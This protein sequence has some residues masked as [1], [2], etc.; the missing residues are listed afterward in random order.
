MHL[1]S[2]NLPA[3]EERRPCMSPRPVREERHRCR[4]IS[5]STLRAAALFPFFSVARRWKPSAGMPPPR[6]SKNGK[7]LAADTIF[8]MLQ[9]TRRS[10]LEFGWKYSACARTPWHGAKR[11]HLPAYSMARTSQTNSGTHDQIPKYGCRRCLTR[12]AIG[13]VSDR[14]NHHHR[15]NRLYDLSPVSFPETA[16]LVSRLLNDR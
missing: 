1:L 8:F 3:T 7:K 4:A 15:P 11:C 10:L 13:D 2:Q 5:D 9:T 12:N 14:Q 6:A 16:R